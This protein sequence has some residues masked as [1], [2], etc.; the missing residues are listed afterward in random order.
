MGGLL[1]LEENYRSRYPVDTIFNDMNKIWSEKYNTPLKYFGGYIEWTLPLTIYGDTHP[2]IML[3]THGYKSPWVDEEDMKK[4]GCMVI[5][6]TPYELV[7]DTYSLPKSML[8]GYK[9]E[10]LE[11]RFYVKNAFNKKREYAIYYVIIPPA[12]ENNYE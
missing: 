11:Y 12:K 4:S 8:E 10:P 9:F 3:D 6:R 7:R 2:N 1:S 5:D